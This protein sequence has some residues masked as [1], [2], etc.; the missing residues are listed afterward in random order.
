MYS[1]HFYFYQ[2][3]FVRWLSSHR[4][5]SRPCFFKSHQT[6]AREERSHAELPWRSLQHFVLGQHEKI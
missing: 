3:F 4:H 1:L 5:L 6:I 2:L